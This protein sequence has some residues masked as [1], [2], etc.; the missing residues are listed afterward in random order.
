MNAVAVPR[1]RVGIYAFALFVLG[2]AI[3][4]SVAV[5]QPWLADAGSY[6]ELVMMAQVFLLWPLLF[7]LMVYPITRKASH[8]MIPVAIGI[9]FTSRILPAD[10]KHYWRYVETLRWIL[11]G[12][13]L[14]AE[15]WVMSL[16]LRSLTRLRG[17]DQPE[18]MI[19]ETVEGHLGESVASRLMATE[20]LMWFFSLASW[21]S[22]GYRYVGQELFTTHR[23]DDNLSTKQAFLILIGA[24]MPI[25]HF[26]IWLWN[27]TAALVVTAISVYGYFWLLG[28]YRASK[29]RPVSIDD[30]FLYLR[31][32][33]LG[34]EKVPLRSIVGACAFDRPMRRQRGLLRHTP[35]MRPNL[36]IQLRGRTEI[37]HVFGT[38]TYETIVL[39]VDEPARLI[40]AINARIHD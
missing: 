28:E 15:V 16:L 22:R 10:W 26:V 24:E 8:V 36:R 13:F 33:L 27:H 25:M 40:A 17:T 4:N 34:N 38:S 37:E 5:R 18:S 9:L 20:L 30:D 14:V 35:A 31:Y 21:R 19:R 6:F 7:L 12:G 2:S 23:H 3:A 32:G 39:G 29:L 11:M 1:S